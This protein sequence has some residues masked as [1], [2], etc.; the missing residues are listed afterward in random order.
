MKAFLPVLI[1]RYEAQRERTN[2]ARTLWK[3][4]R[5][6]HHLDLYL[7]NLRR[8]IRLQSLITAIP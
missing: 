3:E 4:S 2:L 7:F 8:L 6:V 1:R 5:S